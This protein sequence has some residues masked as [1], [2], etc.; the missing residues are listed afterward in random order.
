[1]HS[2]GQREGGRVFPPHSTSL[3]LTLAHSMGLGAYCLLEHHSS[4]PLQRDQTLTLRAVN[5]NIFQFH[6]QG[7]SFIHSMYIN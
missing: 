3:H 7:C 6:I 2:Q 4:P 5:M 1:M